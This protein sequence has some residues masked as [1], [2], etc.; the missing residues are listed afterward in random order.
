MTDQQEVCLG[1]RLKPALK[2]SSRTEKRAYWREVIGAWKV[3]GESVAAF[4]REWNLAQWQFT[5]WKQ[6]LM[7]NNNPVE[8][9]AV[10]ESYGS[11]FGGLRMEWREFIFEVT[12]EGDVRLLKQVLQAVGAI[13]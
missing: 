3:S 5:Y 4:C 9:A 12:Q 7:E 10:P 6:Q 2:G 13:R 8:F 1:E 11:R